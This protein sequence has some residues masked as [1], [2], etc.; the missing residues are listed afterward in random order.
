MTS[1]QCHSATRDLAAGRLDNLGGFA[2]CPVSDSGVGVTCVLIVSYLAEIKA[3]LAAVGVDRRAAAY[4]AQL[5]AGDRAFS[6]AT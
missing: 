6:G 4:L 3:E 2:N 1:S 5:T